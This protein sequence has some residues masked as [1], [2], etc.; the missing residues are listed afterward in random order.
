MRPRASK[1]GSQEPPRTRG[2]ARP[3]ARKEEVVRRGFLVTLG[4]VLILAVVIFMWWLPAYREAELTRQIAEIENIEDA[5]SRKD[6]ALNFLVRNQL[7]DRELLLKALDIAAA[8]F[9][10]SDSREALIDLYETLLVEDLTAWLRYRV[11]ARLDRTLIESGDEAHAARAEELARSMLDVTDAPMETYHWITFFHGRSEFTD[12]ELTLR[13]ALAAGRATDRDEYG[14]WTSML[15]MAYQGVLTDIAERDGLEAALARASVLSEEADDV[16]A[17]AA[18]NAAVYSLAVEDDEET[19]VAAARAM[20]ALEGLTETD[21]ANRV[22]FDMA[23]RGVAPDVAVE[24]SLMALQN[25]STRYDSTM[26]LDTVGWAYY[27]ASDYTD[28]AG[29]LETAVRIMDETPTYDNEM[30]QHLLAAYESG[31]MTDKSIDM[32]A[33]LTAKSVDAD[34][35]SRTKLAGLLTDRDGSAAALESL[36]AGKRYEGTEMAPPF[37]LTDRDGNIVTLDDLKG[38]VLLLA[39]WS[40]G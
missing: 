20:A 28:A 11:T 22:A 27:A 25:A 38:D 36:V 34:D 1:S 13:V 33:L 2:A 12:P 32:L 17:V 37:S 30:V 8:E 23:E 29:Y 39:F 35:P 3:F 7:A 6:A 5:A 19:A 40:Y 15:D 24:L 9:R 26:I 10:D 31:G 14:M 4:V 18:L 21:P 16:P